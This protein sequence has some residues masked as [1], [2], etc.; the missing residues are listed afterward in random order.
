MDRMHA[1]SALALLVLATP[2][3]AQEGAPPMS[4]EEKAAMEAYMKA[5]TPG[6]EHAALAKMAGSYALKIRSWTRPGA[7]PFEST[8]TAVRRMILGERVMVEDVTAT[9]MGQPFT[10]IGMHGYDNVS[11]RHWATWNDNMGTGLMVSE[12]QCD[13]KGAC[14]F[15]GSW[16]DPM[17]KGKVTARMTTRWTA[18]DTE[19]FEMHGPGPDGKEMKMMEITYTRQP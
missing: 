11:G 17:A 9:M 10:G 18:P 13:A 19:L 15:A 12:G 1:R 5:A 4:A 8:G 6:P 2:A 7:P 14:T 3:L 16:Y